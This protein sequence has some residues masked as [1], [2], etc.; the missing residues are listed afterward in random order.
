MVRIRKRILIAACLAMLG[1]GLLLAGWLFPIGAQTQ[2]VD[3]PSISYDLGFLGSGTALDD[4]LAPFEPNTMLSSE[5][6]LLSLLG[7]LQSNCAY[8]YVDGAPVAKDQLDW[9]PLYRDMLSRNLFADCHK[10]LAVLVSERDGGAADFDAVL[11][12]CSIRGSRAWVNV[13]TH[14]LATSTA[15]FRGTVYFIPCP[16]EVSSA[17]V[18]ID[19]KIESNATE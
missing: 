7:Q 1:M 6:D 13:K 10:V 9:D 16:E 15:S 14:E 18:H 19:H 8:I 4:P 2:S 12:S 17:R 3:V 11:Q 5:D